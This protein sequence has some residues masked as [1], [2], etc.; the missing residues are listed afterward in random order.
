MWANRSRRLVNAEKTLAVLCDHLRVPGR[1]ENNV[2]LTILHII[3][4]G[5]S[6]SCYVD[7]QNTDGAAYQINAMLKDKPWGWINEGAKP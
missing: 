6:P 4:F 7:P 5:N 1:G 3:E 2:H